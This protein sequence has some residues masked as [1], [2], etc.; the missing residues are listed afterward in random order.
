MNAV[1]TKPKVY[2]QRILILQRTMEEIQSEF[3]PE[4]ICRAEIFDARARQPAHYTCRLYEPCTTRKPLH[5]TLALRNAKGDAGETDNLI[6]V[7]VSI[8]FS[9]PPASVIRLASG[10]LVPSDWQKIR[11]KIE[12]VCKP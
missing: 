5:P 3:F 7:R 10:R 8:T 6:L 1:I 2:K 12:A 11:E 9:E 4:S